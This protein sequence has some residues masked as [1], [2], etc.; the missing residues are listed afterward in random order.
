MVSIQKPCSVNGCHVFNFYLLY[1]D[2]PIWMLGL[3]VQHVSLGNENMCLVV[4]VNTFSM[5]SI[6]LKNI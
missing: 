3:H 6:G 1:H 2:A 4:H 5:K